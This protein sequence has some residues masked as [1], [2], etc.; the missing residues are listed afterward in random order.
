MANNDEDKPSPRRDDPVKP[1]IPGKVLGIFFIILTTALVLG[2]LLLN[3][4]V[5][6]SLE[7]DC[8]LAHRKDCGASNTSV[9][10][11]GVW[12]NLDLYLLSHPKDS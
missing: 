6:M 12:A 7:E 1:A 2:Y 9:R 8:M 11:L 4:L 3:K 5:D 10:S